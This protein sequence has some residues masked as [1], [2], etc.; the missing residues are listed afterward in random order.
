LIQVTRLDA[1]D[2]DEIGEKGAIK[3]APIERM[4]SK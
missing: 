1:A 2:E 3:T 4:Q